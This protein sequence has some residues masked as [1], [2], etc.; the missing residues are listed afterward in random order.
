MAGVENLVENNV[1]KFNADGEE[2]DSIDINEED[3]KKGFE[4]A[5]GLL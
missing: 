3:W 1:E 4:E 2:V 5:E